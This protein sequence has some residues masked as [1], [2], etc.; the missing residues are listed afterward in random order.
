[1]TAPYAGYLY[2]GIGFLRGKVLGH[3]DTLEVDV[4]IV[5]RHSYAQDVQEQV[6]KWNGEDSPK[7]WA[8]QLKDEP[9]LEINYERK[10]KWLRVET[11]D[12]WGFDVIP[13]LGGSVGNV[14]IYANAGGGGP[15]RGGTGPTTTGAVP[16]ARDA[17]AARFPTRTRRFDGHRSRFSLCRRRRTG[18]PA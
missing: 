6:H 9:T 2:L 12:H 14:A 3:M 5:G 10:W 13:H 1:M 17:R 16:Y 8:N 15:L 4:G 18:R 11:G 7:G